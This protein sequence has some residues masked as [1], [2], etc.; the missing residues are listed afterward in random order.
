MQCN[1]RVLDSSWQVSVPWRGRYQTESS[2]TDDCELDMLIHEDKQ[3]EPRGLPMEKS[4]KKKRAQENEASLALLEKDFLEDPGEPRTLY[5]LG[6]HYKTAFEQH[7][8]NTSA[9]A[10]V[11][12]L[13]WMQ[14][15]RKVT[16]MKLETRRKRR[17]TELT[18]LRGLGHGRPG[19]HRDVASGRRSVETGLGLWGHV[20][21][22]H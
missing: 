8:D 17:L 18:Y 7:D 13:L 21:Q 11:S 4:L 16:M 20:L 14:M 9:A 6:L 2:P 15:I 1:E 3:W 12:Q 19:R 22:Q 10:L 5:Y